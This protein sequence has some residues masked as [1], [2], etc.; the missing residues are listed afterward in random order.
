MRPSLVADCKRKRSISDRENDGVAIA[1]SCK[2]CK[3]T[4]Q[5][6]DARRGEVVTCPTCHEEILAEG[7]RVRN[8]DVFISH[9]HKDRQVA[10]AVCATLE[11]QGIRCWMAPRNVPPGETWG[12]S[13]IDAIGDCVVMIMVFSASSN[14]SKQVLR[15]IERAVSK[16]LE[17]IALRVDDAVPT[18]DFEYFL[19][20][21]TW[22]D[23]RPDLMNAVL[24]HLVRRFTKLKSEKPTLS[25]L[26]QPPVLPQENAKPTRRGK[27]VSRWMIGTIALS[28][29]VVLGVLALS[30]VFE[31]ARGGN[32]VSSSQDGSASNPESKGLNISGV[33]PQGISRSIGNRL[34]KSEDKEPWVAGP[35][36]AVLTLGEH[37]KMEFVWIGPGRFNMGSPADEEG[38]RANEIFHPVRLTYGFWLARHEVTQEQWMAVMG[39][40]NNPST[41]E[42]VSRPVEGVSWL[43]CFRF[44]RKLNKMA[45]QKFRLPSEAEWE[46]ACRA[47]TDFVTGQENE[48]DSIAD[49]A[50]YRQNSNERTH[51][52][53]LLQPNAWGLFDMQ[54][55]VSEFCA[56][57]MGD[58]PT[59]SVTNPIGPQTRGDVIVRGG[60]WAS[61]PADVRPASRWSVSPRAQDNT[62][63]FRICL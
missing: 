47:K 62:I 10:F 5:I 23:A 29:F 3:R 38:R 50:W 18:K 57:R 21:T 8:H 22:L 56:D 13:I 36:E 2:S 54:G 6:A 48:R 20:A 49:Y 51:P 9:S 37:F 27:R 45:G 26:V 4:F 24:E 59:G 35:Y 43:D 30:W 17:I 28:V 33:V 39:D 25:K 16:N 41:F 44:L 55:N 58:Y 40:E 1:L 31:V 32:E 42:G 14:E 15:E 60:A 7:A 46:Y 52:V 19:S 63:G 53:G 61:E 12:A 11:N 34:S